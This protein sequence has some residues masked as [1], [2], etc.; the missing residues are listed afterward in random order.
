MS[1]SQATPAR[2][3]LRGFWSLFVT[4]FQGA[5]S[6]NAFKF[7]VTF[8]IIGLEMSPEQ[9]NRL[10]PLV[11]ALFALPFILFSM[12][13][14]FLADRFS[15][16]SVAIRVKSAEILIMGI[17]AAGLWLNSIPLLLATVFLMS[18][19]SAFFGP[20]KY[21]LLP[22]LLPEKK[23]SWGNGIIGL[24]TFIAIISGTVAAGFLSDAF[25][26]AQV[27]SG[28]LLV[29]L[30]CLGVAASLGIS[31]VP[32][33]APS[34]EFRLNFLGDLLAQ[35]RLIRRDRLLLLAVLG[36]NYLWF[37][38][39]L[40]QPTILF[41]GK[42]FLNLDDLHSGYLQAA[43]AIGIAVGSLAAGYVSGNKIEF[44]LIPLGAGGLAV[45]SA[46]LSREHLTFTEATINLG[47]LGFCGGFYIVPINA[48][49][50]HR[51]DRGAKG[52]V[53]AATAL[54]SFVGIFLASGLYWLLAGVARLSPQQI[55]LFGAVM[56][57]AGTVGIVWLLPA[58]LL[59]LLLWIAT[60]TI[61]RVRVLGRDNIPEKGGALF[62]CNRISPMDGLLL[63]AST[64]RQVRFL[65]RDGVRDSRWMKLFM[66]ITRA[67][68]MP[69]TLRPR[70]MLR[71]LR[72]AGNAVKNG[73]VVCI[74]VKARPAQSNRAGKSRL[75]FGNLVGGADA[76]I[77]PVALL[78]ART[79]GPDC[80]PL[81]SR[82]PLS[83]PYRVT[84][85]YGRR[86]PGASADNE[87]R[88]QT[89]ELMAHAAAQG[90]ATLCK[91]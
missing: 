62:V 48:L 54:L 63:Y 10:V 77:V 85:N 22:E 72:E 89:H 58:S 49:I 32:P 51:P 88:R 28:V 87:V 37:F 76:T 2:A 29:V 40:L 46:L 91:V 6:D 68:P 42:D 34:K 71:A 74:F 80:Q 16:R 82:P 69:E 15:K 27:W 8:L 19:Q 66:R 79:G 65:I 1:Q 39:A 47:L 12:A 13:G 36:S 60:H 5:F 20:A 9:R 31:R 55:F 73:E 17:A 81:R 86:M 4:Q 84:V 35:L 3:S 83:F 59:R 67:I 64:D 61:C 25:G 14:G 21:G 52:G 7:L 75:V 30:A 26:R 43:L 23:L 45:F 70:D 33:A 57:L 50:Q 90:P 11:G 24:G 38:G 53:I 78:S 44:G 41:Y 56:T 18:T